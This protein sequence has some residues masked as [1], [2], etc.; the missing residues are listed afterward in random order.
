MRTGKFPSGP[1]RGRRPWTRGVP[2][3]SSGMT[4]V[5]SARLLGVVAALLSAG[6]WGWLAWSS[7]TGAPS[8]TVP[9]VVVAALLFPGIALA[10]ARA[11]FGDAPLV[12]GVCG[13]IS[14]VPVGLYFLVAPGLLRLLGVPPVLL[15]AAA[16]LLAT[17]DGG[18]TP[19]ESGA[20][21]PASP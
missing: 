19:G 9:P 10:G 2:A 5:F 1:P 7:I 17:A 20:S 8:E 14:L 18:E 4:L 16:V 21:R 15:L 6:G 12:T 3:A 13:L 11:T